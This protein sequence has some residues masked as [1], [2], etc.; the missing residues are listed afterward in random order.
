M[1]ALRPAPTLEGLYGTDPGP[2]AVA[3]RGG[4]ALAPENTLRAFETALSWGLT[5]LETDVRTSADGVPLAFHD[6]LLDRV[7][8]LRGPV[9]AHPW[10]TVRTARVLG[11]EPVLA[12]EDLLGAFPEARFM[13][14]VKD[15]RSVRPTIDA[16]RRTGTAGRVCVAG[17]WDPWLAAIRRECGPALTTAL[18][19]R[20]LTALITCARA[21]TR[22]PAAVAT[23]AYAHVARRVGVLRLMER[24]AFARRLLAM[25]H[26]LGVRVVTWTVNDVAEMQRLLDQGVDGVITDRP[27]L[28]AGVM[29]GRGAAGRGPA[30]APAPA[31]WGVEPA[32]VGAP[33]WRR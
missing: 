28:L 8:D 27:D 12:L 16:V 13:I 32:A 2:H 21:G 30:A 15:E 22:P 6:P 14:D 26:D 31:A 11:A 4:A 3:H 1:T 19:W 29:L 24:P 33:G 5:Y 23:G 18:G 9:S 20:A 7:T 25:A 10:E 17:G